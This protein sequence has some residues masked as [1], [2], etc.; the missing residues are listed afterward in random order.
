MSLESPC[1]R[2]SNQR[3]HKGQHRSLKVPVRFFNKG[4]K[5][6]VGGFQSVHFR[7]LNEN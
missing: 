4:T 7:K 5:D 2:R 1:W 6:C 3:H